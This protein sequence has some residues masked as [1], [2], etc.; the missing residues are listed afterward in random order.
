MA[1]G[2]D[3][4]VGTRIEH[5]ALQGCASGRAAHPESEQ[6]LCQIQAREFGL[7]TVAVA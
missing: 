2:F 6:M 1:I 3:V 7:R 5:E 4:F